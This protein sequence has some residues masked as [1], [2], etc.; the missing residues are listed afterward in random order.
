[1]QARDIMTSE[2]VSVRPDVPIRQIA[3]LLRDKGIS[4]VPVVDD[5]GAPV[6]MVSE[7]DLVGRDEQAREARRD[8]WLTL[9]AEGTDLS[10]DFLASLRKDGTR[11]REVMSAPVVTVAENADLRDVARLLTEHRIKRVPV[12]R[13]GRIVGI[14]SRA[15]LLRAMTVEESAPA[16]SR[17]AAIRHDIFAGLDRHFH[18]ERHA[19]AAPT[20]ARLP[21]AAE[22]PLE[23]EDFRHLVADFHHHET[24]HQSEARRAAVA[25]R[26]EAAKELIDQH[27]S[28]D[29][30]RTLLHQARQA[31]EHGAK[32]F[33]LLRFPREVLSDG[34]R[35]V[36]ALEPDWPQTLRG[37]PAEIYRCWQRDLQP[38]GFGIAARVLDFP[39]GMPGDIGLFLIWGE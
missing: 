27:I 37:E 33:L 18:P 28:D 16:R 19:A 24:E 23:V 7:G 11:A 12:V 21:S 1:M 15:D 2:V 20:A 3:R 9:L 6:G 29:N 36:N 14:V 5:G 13:D 10:P 34:G 31:A 35:T 25:Q 4:A 26:Q 17:A 32:E 38:H 22:K 8:W 39:G 30:W